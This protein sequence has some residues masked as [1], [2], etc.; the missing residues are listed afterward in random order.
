MT[1]REKILDNQEPRSRATGNNKFKW[2]FS[3]TKEEFLKQYE[4][5]NF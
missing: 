1:K 3:K 5:N 2:N 4:T